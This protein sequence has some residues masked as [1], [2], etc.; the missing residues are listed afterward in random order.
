M[1]WKSLKEKYH[2]FKQQS[3]ATPKNISDVNTIRKFGDISQYVP[4][5]SQD[6]PEKIEIPILQ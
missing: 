4:F 6:R 2:H 3:Y 1:P 5:I